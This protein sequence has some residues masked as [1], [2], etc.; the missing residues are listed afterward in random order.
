[1][2]IM[3]FDNK[4]SITFRIVGRIGISDH[5]K[6]RTV[7]MQALERHSITTINIDIAEINSI[8]SAALAMLKLCHEMTYERTHGFGKQPRIRL[9]QPSPLVRQILCMAGFDQMFEIFPPDRSPRKPGS[10]R[11]APTLDSHH[12]D[13]NTDISR[14]CVTHDFIMR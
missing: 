8:D 10:L 4:D 5:R 14:Q 3:Q 12:P 7:Y 11:A 1:M 13:K 6:L 2:D 9:V